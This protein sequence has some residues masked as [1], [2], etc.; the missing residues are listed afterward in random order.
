MS[1]KS[2]QKKRAIHASKHQHREKIAGRWYLTVV[3]RKTCCAKCA[4]IL[5]VG[6]EMV[7]RHTPREALCKSCAE[8]DPNVR[9]R[10]SATWERARRTRRSR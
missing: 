9:P 1:Y 7:Y 5:S 3:K 6:G 8:L 4:G 2:R 10:P